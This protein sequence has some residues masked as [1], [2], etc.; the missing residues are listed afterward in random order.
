[1]TILTV[2]TVDHSLFVNLYAG[3]LLPELGIRTRPLIGDI[4]KSII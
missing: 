3:G 4:V 1:M 2:I